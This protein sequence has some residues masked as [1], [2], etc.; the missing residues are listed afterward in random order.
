MR[1]AAAALTFAS[2]AS[3]AQAHFR[4]LFPEPRGLFVADKE[5]EFCGGYTNAVSNR[6][7]FPLTGGF[8]TIRSGHPSWTAGV[9]LSTVENPSNFGDFNVSGQQQFARYYSSE[10]N[11]GTFCIPLD[12]SQSGISGLQDGSNV[13]IQI[14]FTGGDGNL[15]QC[16]D[17]TL[18]TTTNITSGQTCSN[19]TESGHNSGNGT[20]SGNAPSQAGAALSL[21][22]PAFASLLLGLGGVVAA[23]L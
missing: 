5:P 18:R 1:F 16:A 8:F 22:G 7:E 19:Q 23:L 9:L 4:L 12:L 14:V 11:A 20:T 15:Y 3:V 6:S 17:L 21:Q 10:P 13:T 2:F